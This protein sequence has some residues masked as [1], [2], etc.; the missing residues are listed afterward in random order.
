[1]EG[2]AVTNPFDDDTRHFD[3]LINDEEQYSLWPQ[4]LPVPSGWTSVA[5]GDL[6]QCSAYVDEHWTDMRPASLRNAGSQ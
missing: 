6:R 3:V 5:S 4:G 1:M 2:N